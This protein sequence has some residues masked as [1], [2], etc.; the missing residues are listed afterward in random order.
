M[1]LEQL[2]AQLAD[3]IGKAE[4]ISKRAVN[5]KGEVRS[6]N[7]SEQQEYNQVKDQIQSVRDA[8]SRAEDLEE[9]K[10]KADELNTVESRAA[11]I[12]VVR[13]ENHDESGQYRGFKSLGE[14]LQAVH[15]AE[16]GKGEDKRL[17][18]IRAASG[19]NEAI[20]SEGGFLVQ[21]DFMVDL[22]SKVFSA[23]ELASKCRQITIS[24]N[25]NTLELIQVDETSRVD[26]SRWGGV[27]GYWASEAGTVTAS[28][29]ALTQSRIV[30]EK[31]MALCY[32]TDE[33]LADSV[34]L[35]SI[36]EPAF[37]EEMAF[38]LDDAIINGD[39]VGK[40]LGILNAPCL[41]SVSAETSQAAATFKWENA[42]K[43]RQRVPAKSRKSGFW[44]AND[45]VLPQLEAMYV[46]LGSASGLPV[47]QPA[48]AFGNGTETLYGRPILYPEACATLGT[49]GDV[50]FADLNEYL[51]VKK[52]SIDA[53]T[54][55]HVRF[56]YGENTFRFTQ[57]INGQPAW[58]SAVTPFKGSNTK[59]PFTA[60]ATRS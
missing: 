49:V 4:G 57:R 29:P 2:R 30:A 39:G 59:S 45:D 20:D 51:L 15:R 60:V 16:S 52:G 10:R 37:I 21:S 9:H 26:G 28:K 46:P 58:K 56:L 1:T 53:Q 6:L 55:I 43:M 32:A 44:L 40:P 33:L 34:A 27:R 38:K 50:I 17:R 35:Q 48:G 3:L 47:F 13:N 11:K 7:E 31:L 14:Q 23:G 18:E 12:T 5:E 25:S 24:A 36:I 42:S 19:L 54:S 22:Q 41:V 8:I